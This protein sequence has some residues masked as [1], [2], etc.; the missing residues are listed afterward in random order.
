LK[1][2]YTASVL[3]ALPCALLLA[4]AVPFAGAAPRPK[5]EEYPVHARAG[6]AAI[7]AD[8]LAR[9]IPTAQRMFAS[10]AYL[11]VEVAI[12]PDK[13]SRAQVS[14]GQFA[15]RVNGKRQVLPQAPGMVAASF[16]YPDWESGPVFEGGA[17]M[18]GA[19]VGIG[20]PR[21]APRF[22]GDRRPSEERLPAPPRVPD[23]TPG[24]VEQQPARSAEDLIQEAALPD[25]PASG[26]VS[27]LLYFAF[28]GKTK[29]IRKL[30]LLYRAGPDAPAVILPLL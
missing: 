11:V 26:P 2:D 15:L 19:G 21:P 17:G 5:P 20:G 24:G 3:K 23:Q 30:E 9:S 28:K 18:G 1:Q 25:G 7:A 4:A 22:P 29:S 13:G 6:S 27:G 14:S 10:E 16:K 12:Y 8:Y